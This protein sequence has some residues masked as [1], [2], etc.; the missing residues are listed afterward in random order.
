MPGHT[1]SWLHAFWPQKERKS[2]AKVQ[3]FAT[4]HHVTFASRCKDWF[5]DN[6][7][8]E[9]RQSLESTYKGVNNNLTIDCLD[10]RL[11]CFPMMRHFVT[12][13]WPIKDWP[14]FC[15]KRRSICSGKAAAVVTSDQLCVC[16]TAGE[17]SGWKT[18]NVLPDQA[19]ISLRS[20]RWLKLRQQVSERQLHS[21]SSASSTPLPQDIGS[22]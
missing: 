12:Q 3:R 13:R 19:L 7:G 15:R 22:V 4:H 9:F 8:K 20:A 11:A 1:N 14:F 6:S 2:N 5:T 18:T 10:N 16:L 21:W 17:T